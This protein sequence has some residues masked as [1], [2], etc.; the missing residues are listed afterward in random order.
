MAVA[1]VRDE[2]HLAADLESLAGA[3]ESLE[4]GPGAGEIAGNRDR[5]V[6]SLRSYLIPRFQ[7][8]GA[9][10]TV[11]FAGPTGS[12]KSTLVN[13][14]ANRELSKTGPLR[15]TTT[16]PVV[17][18]SPSNVSSC[19]TLHGVDCEV[20]SG[21]A[22]ILSMMILVDTPDIDST[23][24]EHRQQAESL[25]DCADVVVFVTSALR[26][27]DDVA[28]QVLRRAVSRG[29][30]V[31]H[32]L[33][34]ATSGTSGAV[35]DLKGRLRGAGLDDRLVTIPE[36]HL[37]PGGQRVP[38]LAV[39]S[40]GRRLAGIAAGRGSAA[41][42]TRDRVLD[43]TIDQV[44]VLVRAVSELNEDL[45]ARA[46]RLSLG[47]AERAVG[48]DLSSLRPEHAMPPPSSGRFARRRWLR[49][50]QVD[51]T[52]IGRLESRVVEDISALVHAD[53]RAW[54]ADEG[55]ANEPAALDGRLVSSAAPAIR[56]GVEGWVHFVRQLAAEHGYG[57]P[58]LVEKVL[59]ESALA[60]EPTRVADHLLGDQAQLLMTRVG[61]EL[62]GR[63]GVLYQHVGELVIEILR[64]ELGDLDTTGT[65]SALGVVMTAS[66]LVDA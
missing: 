16:A 59:L 13:S 30:D 50:N 44:A 3:L 14:L 33:N 65:R 56:S 19:R 34:R 9:P 10:L 25:V 31:I 20:V 7:D 41:A 66:S 5:L 45:D 47:L 61:R 37:L 48:L 42:S 22:P 29:A 46:A 18:A 2:Q 58:L 64:H 54:I 51:A 40:L 24:T 32:V 6:A 53:L 49:S 8:P 21:S 1:A 12:G 60:G 43:V 4:I 23:T 15:P 11:V 17:L 36:H 26:Y 39:R 28:W 38:S 52:D 55:H 35:V 63:I 62:T 57:D 27:A